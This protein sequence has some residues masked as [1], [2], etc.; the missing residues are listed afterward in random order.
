MIAIAYVI[1]SISFTYFRVKT[2]SIDAEEVFDL[3][4]KCLAT[5]SSTEKK[6]ATIKDAEEHYETKRYIFVKNVNSLI[7]YLNNMFYIFCIISVFSFARNKNCNMESIITML[8]F[9]AR[10]YSSLLLR[11]RLFIESMGRLRI[12][13]RELQ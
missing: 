10:Y 3:H 5:Y 9:I 8:L 1:I 7:L 4:G 11:T 12:L 6:E 2:L 13:A